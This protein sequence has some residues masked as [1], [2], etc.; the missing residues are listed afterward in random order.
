MLKETMT[1]FDIAAVV[2]EINETI[3][4]T[5]IDNIYQINA[6]TLVFRLRK[7][8][9]APANLLIEAGR[10][11][12][13]TSYIVSKPSK[14]PTFC[15]AMR[16]YLK[17][18][19]ITEVKQHEFE[20]IITIKIKAK[21]GEFQLVSE[22]FGEGN[23]ILVN[24]KNQIL[25]ALTYKRMRDRNILRK[26]TFQ[27]PPPSGRNPLKLNREEFDKIRDAGKL[28]VVKELTQFLG[29]GGLYAEE[30][31]LRAGIEKNTMCQLLAGQQIDKIFI[32]LNNILSLATAGKAEPRIVVDEKGE[33][34]D[35]TPIQ[36]KKYDDYGQRKFEAFNEAI[37]EYY[38]KA[39]LKEKE[40]SGSKELEKELG[41]LERI[42]QNQQK[43][44]EDL[45]KKIELNK[46][47]GDL[48]Y[49]HFGE[50]QFLL[51]E[52]V[53]AKKNGRSWEQM[54][55]D[56]ERNKQSGRPPATYFHSLQPKGL[57]LNVS[58]DDQIFALNLRHSIQEN[59]ANYYAE[60][61]KAERKSKGANEALRET[62]NKIEESKQRWAVQT[63]ESQK[64]L[65][66]ARK[67]AWYEKFR[68]FNTSE[69]FLVIGGRD[70][71][72]NEILVKKYMEP[73]D[74]VFHADVIGAPFVLIK[75]EGKTS[76]EQALIESAQFAASYSRAWKGVSG[77]V[78]VYWVKPEQVSKSPPS[79][80]YI[81]KGAFIIKGAKNYIRNIPL[82]IAIGIKAEDEYV[83]VVGGPVEAIAKQADIYVKV[84]PGKLTSGKLA[85]QIRRVLAK[86]APEVL[87]KRILE[88]PLEEIQKFIPLGEGGIKA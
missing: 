17:N 7:P 35:V 14:P 38:A 72:T 58:L 12:H 16:K 50:L 54:V 47:I 69:S 57:I 5:F 88:I 13:L 76:T 73:Q 42:L 48:I 81:P 53:D 18:G 24:Q 15:M 36:L 41:K 62:R 75:T 55:S 29:V 27:Y 87:Q 74:I 80:Q 19:K 20:R 43:T 11:F 51:Q 85:K 2:Q 49:A 34:I 79:G 60:A 66:K 40:V 21:E 1:S 25:H 8:S 63:K 6:V 30:I 9:Q 22:L 52:I 59:A 4:G 67:K 78:D 83:E 26:E 32:Q 31:L 28:E 64:P 82:Q 10:R 37:D 33:L 3:T 44:V 65:L 56:V 86:K 77:T 61:K 70:A 84:V 39:G 23:I 71:M 68:W 45:K 46:K